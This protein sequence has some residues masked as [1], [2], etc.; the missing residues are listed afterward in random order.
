[1]KQYK[2]RMELFSFHDYAG[3]AA[4]MEKLARKGWLLDKIGRMGW[5]YRRIEPQNLKFAVAYFPPASTF[6]PEPSES[7]L[8]F[9]D[10]CEEAGWKLAAS[11]AQIQVFYNENPDAVPLETDAVLQVENIHAA[12]KKTTLLSHWILGGLGLFQLIVWLV[13]FLEN[14]ALILADYGGWFRFISFANLLV[15]SAVELISYYTWHKKAVRLAE[16]TG[17]LYPTQSHRIFQMVSLIIIVGA[18]ILWVFLMQSRRMKVTLFLS[19]LNMTL[20]VAAVQGCQELLK[21]LKVSKTKNKVITLTVDFVLAFLLIGMLPNWIIRMDLSDKTPV[22]TYVLYGRERHVYNDPLP[23][24]VEDLLE[25]DPA[26]YSKEL[27]TKRTVL[28][29]YYD[30]FQSGRRDWE[31]D[32][33]W[34]EYRL[35]IL[36]IPSWTEFCWN[37]WIENYETEMP[38]YRRLEKLD[39]ASWKAEEAYRAFDR[40]GNEKEWLVRWKDRFVRLTADWELTEEQMSILA[41]RFLNCE[42]HP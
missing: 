17:Q 28:A 33:P 38:F 14:P 12:A 30:A 15:L 16:E 3:L 13:T 36:E 11:N 34:L 4:N 37:G 1:M 24:C 18:L 27:E 40:D 32:L 6:D 19:L 23:V 2:T 41:E 21:K 35:V 22:D 20:L 9:R 42:K 26:G 10:Y 39:A 7:E 5:R 25:V 29:A 8:R 31:T